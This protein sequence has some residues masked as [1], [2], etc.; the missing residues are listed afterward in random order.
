MHRARTTLYHI[1]G[2]SNDNNLLTRQAAYTARIG[3]RHTQDPTPPAYTPNDATSTTSSIYAKMEADDSTDGIESLFPRLS[4]PASTASTRTGKA[5][6]SRQDGLPRPTIMS[7]SLRGGFKTPDNGDTTGWSETRR[8]RSEDIASFHIELA[9]CVETKTITTTTTT[10]RS[11]PPLLV[12]PPRPL[13]TLDSKQ[14]PLARK[15]TPDEIASFTYE[16]DGETVHFLEDRRHLE[17][18]VSPAQ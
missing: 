10:K 11:Y 14:Y 15:P 13:E 16:V 2:D 17:T 1:G 4:K 9:E 5:S 3:R 8:L 7:K 12:Q 18:L 6:N